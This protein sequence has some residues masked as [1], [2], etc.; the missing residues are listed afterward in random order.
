MLIYTDEN[1][2]FERV[3]GLGEN[4]GGGKYTVKVM[5]DEGQGST[6]LMYVS[7]TQAAQVISQLNQ[8]ASQEEF[9]RIIAENMEILGIDE[10]EYTEKP[11]W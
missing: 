10:A 8:A 1:G 3:F 7:E 4:Y 6:E 2:A 11:R 5:G 9:G